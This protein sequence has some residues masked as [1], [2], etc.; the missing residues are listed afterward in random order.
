[1][2][3]KSRE[4]IAGLIN[5]A[6]FDVDIPSKL[7]RLRRLNHELSKADFVL[8]SEFVSPLL[9]LLSDRFGPVRKFTI[10]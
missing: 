3:A 9:E 10:E 8:V 5:S 1:M 6:K 2:A 4:K 7:D